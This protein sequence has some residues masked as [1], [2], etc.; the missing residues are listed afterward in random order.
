V[1]EVLA[2]AR[3]GLTAAQL[4]AVTGLGV[5]ELPSVLDAVGC[6][7][8]A[9][10]GVW[11]IVHQS[12][13]DWLISQ[14]AKEFRIDVAAGRDRL[15]EFCRKWKSNRDPYALTHVVTHLLDAGHVDDAAAVIR[16]GLFEVRNDVVGE[17]RLDGEDTRALTA[18][19]I[20]APTRRASSPWRGPR[21]RG[22]ATG[23][24][25]R[26]WRL[27]LNRRASSTTSSG[28]C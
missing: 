28:N 19:L 18:A 6:F 23:S 8:A 9:P 10:S 1:L 27:R 17:P 4:A 21:I 14:D 7:A 24:L 15:L 13:A 16:D 12:I 2:A 22:S 3:G 26:W 5:D 11:R 20:A 25:P